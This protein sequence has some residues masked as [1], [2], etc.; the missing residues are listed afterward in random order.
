M[1]AVP[2]CSGVVFLIAA[3]AYGQSATP[4]PSLASQRAILD[5]YCVNCHNQKLK[6]AGLTLDT[7]DLTHVSEHAEQWEKVVRK[8][9]AGLMPPSGLPRPNPAAYETLTFTIDNELDRA[10]AANPHLAPPGVHRANRTEYAYAIHNLL[11][12]DI[13][14]AAF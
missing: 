14:P 6:T 8:L 2:T 3:M 10:A 12:L 1:K 11:A 5:Q 9:R 7:L 13:D 4:A